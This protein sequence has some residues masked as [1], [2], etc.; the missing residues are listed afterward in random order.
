MAALEGCWRT[1]TI[2][3]QTVE[4]FEPAEPVAERAIL[5][6]P[7]GGR[8]A[9]D[10]A[11]LTRCLSEKRIRAISP[12]IMSWW[13]DRSEPRFSNE[14]TPLAFLQQALLPWVETRWSAGP[15]N[16]RLLGWEE[17]GQ[18]ILQLAFR[19]PGDFP[20][21]AAIDAAIDFHEV[22][23]HDA[24]ITALFP[25]REAA[26]QE[27]ALLRLHPAGWPRRMLLIADRREQ[28]FDGVDRLEMKLR[29]GGVPVETDFYPGEAT[30]IEDR[31]S[32]IARAME[33]LGREAMGLPVVGRR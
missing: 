4:I 2:T 28:W 17:G 24:V 23:G 8:F 29:S 1:I 31:A 30:K 21:I 26:R 32:A 20:A 14:Q 27:T 9:S 19:R 11:A 15:P 3:D 33:H 16:I 25:S 22:H 6:L 5:V 13:L 18:G 10:E 12:T 7:G